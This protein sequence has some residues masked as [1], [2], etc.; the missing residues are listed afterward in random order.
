VPAED[1]DG[2]VAIDVS[3][4]IPHAV[5]FDLGQLLV[6]LVHAGQ[7]PAAVLPEIHPALAPAFT[8]GLHAAGST[9]SLDEVAF[10]YGASLAVR[11][12]LTS[13]PFERLGEPPTPELAATFRERAALTGFIVD[14]GLSLP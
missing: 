11:A 4:Q 2:F 3:F 14:L 1:P 10:G 12:G 13:L 7:L 5:G 8:E 9:A 6:G